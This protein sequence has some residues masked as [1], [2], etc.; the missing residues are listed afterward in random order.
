MNWNLMAFFLFPLTIKLGMFIKL[1]FK[2]T[3]LSIIFMRI[4]VITHNY[5]L[6]T[7]GI[8]NTASGNNL[9]YN[10]I[11]L[12]SLLSLIS[13]LLSAPAPKSSTTSL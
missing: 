7:F 6:S 11:N 12:K 10:T 2:N 1:F 3:V 13:T 5:K 9:Q 4:N 8:N